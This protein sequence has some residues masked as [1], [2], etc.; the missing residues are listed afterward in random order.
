[1]GVQ[2][3]GTK[4]SSLP[5]IRAPVPTHRDSRALK[6]DF[7]QVRH[8]VGGSYV[9]ARRA[10]WKAEDDQRS[11]RMRRLEAERRVDPRRVELDTVGKSDGRE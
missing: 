4:P 8:N 9:L 2:S 10:L 7:G 5:A 11:K 6:L 3:D 1:M